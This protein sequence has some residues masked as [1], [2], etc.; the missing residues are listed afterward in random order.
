MEIWIF[1]TVLVGFMR[2][3]IITVF[4]LFG[5]TGLASPSADAQM[6]EDAKKFAE[7]RSG[8]DEIYLDATD[9]V[10]RIDDAD[11]VILE[12][13]EGIISEQVARANLR[14][15]SAI[16]QYA[17]YVEGNTYS[18]PLRNDLLLAIEDLMV[19]RQDFHLERLS[20]VR[21]GQQLQVYGARV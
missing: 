12:F 15:L 5:A 6:I 10:Y 8:F 3:V 18:E 17:A 4:L 13:D 7:W 20:L 2:Q 1:S 19:E 14:K 9:L 21:S 16:D 11:A